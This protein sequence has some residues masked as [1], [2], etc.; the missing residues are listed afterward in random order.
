LHGCLDLGAVLIVVSER[1][2]RRLLLT[3]LAFAQYHET[4]CRH[5]AAEHV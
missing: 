2:Q 3:R 4:L 5:L 1:R